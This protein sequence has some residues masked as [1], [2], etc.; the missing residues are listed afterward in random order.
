MSLPPFPNPGLSRQSKKYGP[1][2]PYEWPQDKVRIP[3]GQ[4]LM[5][6][7]DVQNGN[8]VK[9]EGAW[10]TAQW[11][12]AAGS[13]QRTEQVVPI[14]P[15]GDF[16]CTH[17]VGSSYVAAGPIFTPYKVSIIDIRTG[18]N[19][20]YPFARMGM[21]KNQSYAGLAGV[22]PFPVNSRFRPTASLIQPFCFT[23]NGGIRVIVET[24]GS[25]AEATFN[26]L[27]F[28]GWKEYQYASR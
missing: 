13:D 11:N 20:T 24:D 2:T 6:R 10:Y 4:G 26:Q 28:I 9:K 5:P 25:P 15:D 19:L 16:W 18:H 17:I 22:V 12:F 3:N 14:E 27:S 23:R 21:F 8:V 7:V 1:L